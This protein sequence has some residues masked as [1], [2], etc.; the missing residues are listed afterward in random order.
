MVKLMSWRKGGGVLG[1]SYQMLEKLAGDSAEELDLLL[2]SPGLV[3]LDEGHIPCNEGSQIWQ[4]KSGL[5][6]I[7]HLTF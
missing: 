6:I 5:K 3:V 4:V 1:V 7:N 2:D